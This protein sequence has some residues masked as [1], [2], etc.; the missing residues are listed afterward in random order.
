MLGWCATAMTALLLASGTCQL[1]R[2]SQGGAEPSTSRDRY[3]YGERGSGGKLGHMVQEVLLAVAMSVVVFA[4]TLGL[5]AALFRVQVRDYN[6]TVATDLLSDWATRQELLD[7]AQRE[8]MAPPPHV[9]AALVALPSPGLRA[10]WTDT[11][12]ASFD[13]GRTDAGQTPAPRPGASPV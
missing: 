7:P 13:G 11:P 2:R 8:R 6:R 5:L 9:V 1:N 4:G 10:A 12:A 3:H